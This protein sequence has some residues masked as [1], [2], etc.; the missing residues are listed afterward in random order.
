M[1]IDLKPIVGCIIAI[2]CFSISEMS[3]AVIIGQT[4]TFENGTTQDWIES[5]PSPNQPTNISDGGPQGIGDNYLQNVS[6]GGVGA[7]SRQVMYNTAQWTGNFINAGVTEI[8]A[9]ARVF[10][11]PGASL[12]VAFQSG[13]GTRFA[14]TEPVMVANDSSWHAVVFPIG[15]DDLTR[16]S[17]AAA[18]NVALSNVT[19]M[20]LLH[21]S[22]PSWRGDVVSM[23]LGIDNIEAATEVI[24]TDG[25][26]LP[27][28]EDP[29]DD[30]DGVPDEY[31]LAPS[32]S[33]IRMFFDVG[34]GNGFR[35]F[36]EALAFHGITSGCGNS[37]YCPNNPVTREQMAVFLLRGIHGSSYTP[38]AIGST[39]FGDVPMTNPF[40]A[41]IEQ[42]AAEGITSGCGG[43]N[44]CPK[45]AVTRE[46]MAVFLLRGKYGSGYTPPA[47]GSTRF[48]DVPMSNP[49][50]AWI[51]QLAVE[52]V[53]SGCGNNDYCP[54]SSVTRAQMAV[55]LIRTF[56]LPLYFTPAGEPS[57]IQ[58]NA[59]TQEAVGVNDE[60]AT[61]QSNQA[62][63]SGAT[64]TLPAALQLR[65]QR[66]DAEI[67]HPVSSA[68][69]AW[70]VFSSD[71][72]NLVPNDT[73]EMEDI[74][75]YQTATDALRRISIGP[76]GEQANSAS[77]WAQI[78]ATGNTIIYS[79]KASNLTG[80]DSN[81][82]SDIFLYQPE[83]NLT[84]RLSNDTSSGQPAQPAQHPAMSADG[85]EIVFDQGDGIRLIQ[86]HDRLF[87]ANEPQ[88]ETLG[89][90]NDSIDSHHPALSPSGRYLVYIQERTDAVTGNTQCKL[91][92]V[93]RQ[94]DTTSEEGC[95]DV[96]NELT[97]PRLILDE[98]TNLRW[99]EGD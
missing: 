52:G 76:Q 55:F 90:H 62:T 75:L 72:S 94:D 37:N 17:G 8:H 59:Q 46:Q 53:T 22:S 65:L 78:D 74:F 43:G 2:F 42:L 32:D 68:D 77:T 16:V 25:D 58:A 6:S 81:G 41:W 7:G 23:T 88:T 34:P 64:N 40:A 86:R 44:Y 5:A 63:A 39:R 51:E 36:I 3:S 57:T 91:I 70:I 99:V 87:A 48:N 60:S 47:I 73:N 26:G 71:A 67:S 56:G 96:L 4:D 82:V 14:S 69:G 35:D 1:T 61:D 19:E 21:S 89:L 9:H 45:S 27:D 49:Y 38:P 95:P 15:I 66:A 98:A 79:S 50:A 29:D 13:D 20:R 11:G 54:K 84:Q 12:R 85:S 28:A 18:H 33:T 24:D 97:D 10:A 30:N 93:D 92:W 31:D 80:D 83:I